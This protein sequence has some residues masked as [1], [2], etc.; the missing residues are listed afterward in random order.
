[1]RIAAA[2][3]RTAAVMRTARRL[4]RKRVPLGTG[5]EVVDLVSNFPDVT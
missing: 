4:P 3:V 5:I 2:F 1:M